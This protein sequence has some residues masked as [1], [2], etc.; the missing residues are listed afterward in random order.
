V[1]IEQ[2]DL[3]FVEGRDHASQSSE[4][5][6]MRDLGWVLVLPQPLV[7]DLGKRPSSVQVRKVTSTTSLGRTQCTLR[8]SSG[9]PKQLSRGVGMASGMRTIRSGSRRL[10]SSA[11]SRS[12]MPVPARPA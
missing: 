10:R 8:S 9:R 3:A 12:V 1:A 11:I 5:A 7:D 2:F 4:R 6:L